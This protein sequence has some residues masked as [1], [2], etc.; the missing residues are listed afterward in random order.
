[1]NTQTLES[2]L[3]QIRFSHEDIVTLLS[4]E[5]PPQIEQ[6]RQAAEAV[7][8]EL[9]SNLV[10][11]RGIVEFSNNCKLDCYYCGIR[12]SNT[13]I[14]RFTLTKPEIVDAALWCAREGYGSVVL[15][16][17]E[18]A[19]VGFVD[20]VEDIIR[21]IK[22]DSVSETLPQGL[23]ITLCVGEQTP[24]IYKRFYDA[25]AHRYLLRIE[26]TDPDLF[27]QIHPKNQT[28]KSRL[29]CLESLQDIGYQVGTGS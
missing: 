29:A 11:Y 3:R 14:E 6:L 1:M 4:L 7:T 13:Q 9:C 10:Y 17:G 25:G 27:Q 22:T 16:S 26:T 2:L 8:F 20:F 23:G 19:D 15:Q 18:R 21:T 28:L 24:E 12:R 5:D